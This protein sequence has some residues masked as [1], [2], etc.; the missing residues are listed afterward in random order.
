[1]IP[2]ASQ[3]ENGQDLATHLLNAQD[4]EL[5]ELFDM[6]RSVAR[7]LHGAFAE[8]EAIA[9]GLTRARQYLCSLSVNP[10]E[11]QGRLTR[12]QY[13]DYID[14]VEA[15]LGLSDQPRAIVFHHK[16]DEGGAVREHCHVVWSRT[17]VKNKR[18]IPLPF[19]K[20]KLMAV[21][22]EFARDH[23]L[24]LP[25]GYA[26]QS[27]EARR[28]RQLSAYDCVKQKETGLSH[29]E[30]MA[31][32]TDAWRRSDNAKAFVAALE[33][34]GYVLARG[35]NETRIVLV[36]F[37]GH[38][39]ALTRLIDDA[40]V[41]TKHVRDFLGAAFAP[42]KL[43]TV[44]QAQEQ[45]EKRRT[46]IEAFEAAAREDEELE[47]LARRQAVRRKE[48]EAQAALL[49]RQQHDERM[50]LAALHAT[51]RQ[52][53]KASYLAAQRRIR[54]DRARRRPRG[55]AAFLGRV[56]GVSL[57]IRKVQRYRDRKRYAAYLV[58]R[59]ELKGGQ[60]ESED[61][62]AVQQAL[63][64][65]DSERRLRALDQVEQRERESLQQAQR[66]KRRQR[67]NARHDH[68]PAVVRAVTPQRQGMAS[69]ARVTVSE[70]MSEAAQLLKDGQQPVSLS[71][72][73]ARATAVA[74]DDG[75]GEGGDTGTAEPPRT[76]K[77]KPRARR[78]GSLKHEFRQAAS[79]EQ[80]EGEGGSESSEAPK[81]AIEPPREKRGRRK[82][83]SRD[84]PSA[85]NRR[86]DPNGHERP[87]RPGGTESRVR[88][89]RPRDSKPRQ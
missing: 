27:D 78:R 14:R 16:R 75:E 58:W 44:E 8:W 5:V 61:A 73:F 4:N 37:Y 42:D 32:V 59:D 29:E 52:R 6:R 19:F 9:K 83:K 69:A 86:R 51:E 62:L 81:P 48:V 41:R 57:V 77:R 7:D 65:A 21:T 13:L 55:L 18:A 25:P 11:R 34:L 15:A 88:R 24:R 10:D 23:G 35:R 3:R 87:D 47:Q 31:A 22:R 26:R 40:S 82:R 50:Q 89:R 76:R 70:Q 54:V 38:T 64:M 68:L 30:R 56:S 84:E 20:E 72:A 85:D 45:A 1:M 80:A 79:G 60:K 12:A 66:R 36:D 53:L 46:A 39:T 67:I 49:R 63:H 28:N 2:F 33:A 71:R 74:T 43:P 17:D